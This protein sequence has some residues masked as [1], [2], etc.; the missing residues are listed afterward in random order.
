MSAQAQGRPSP[1]DVN[2]APFAITEGRIGEDGLILMIQGELDLGTQPELRDRLGAALE[3]GVHRL[4][5][6]LSKVTFIDS[7]S[8]AAIV[9]AQNRLGADGRVAVVLAEDSYAML[10]FEVG[11]MA[12]VLHLVHSREEALAHVGA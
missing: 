11:G 2:V 12:S 8:V 3:A 5:I 6:D 9:K 1:L 10:I 7:V 4:V